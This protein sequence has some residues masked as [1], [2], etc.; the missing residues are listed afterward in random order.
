MAVLEVLTGEMSVLRRAKTWEISESENDSDA[1]TKPGLKLDESSQTIPVSTDSTEDNRSDC[2]HEN[3]QPSATKSESSQT[4]TLSPPRPD[5]CGTPSPARKRRSKEEMEA[6]RQKAKERKEAR[7]RQRAA[8]AQEKEERRQEQQIRRET[9]E[10]LKSLRPENCLKCL[11][12]CIDPG[13][14]VTMLPSAVVNV[15][16]C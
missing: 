5:G 4:S 1:E 10:H 14:Q 12:V 2:K 7:E 3:L 9:A 16:C 8:K 15:Q 6:D 13:T 11:T